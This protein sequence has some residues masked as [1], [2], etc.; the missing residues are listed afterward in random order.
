MP[1]QLARHLLGALPRALT[2]MT[3][4]EICKAEI[5]ADIRRQRASPQTIVNQAWRS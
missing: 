5:A 3:P 4:T 1:L 2:W